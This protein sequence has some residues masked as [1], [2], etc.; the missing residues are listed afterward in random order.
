[1]ITGASRFAAGHVREAAGGSTGRWSVPAEATTSD[2]EQPAPFLETAATTRSV[3]RARGAPVSI[4]EVPGLD[5]LLP[6]PLPL[7][8]LDPLAALPL[9]LCFLE[10]FPMLFHF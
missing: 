10:G 9:P 4:G 6:L 8:R 7:L 3:G 5:G 1:M 2:P